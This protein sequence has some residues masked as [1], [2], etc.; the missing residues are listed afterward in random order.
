MKHKYKIH[1]AA[2]YTQMLIGILLPILLTPYMTSHLGHELYGLWVLLSSVMVYFVLSSL[3]FNTTLVREISKTHDTELINQYLSTMLFFLIGMTMIVSIF[4]II[5]Y[6]NFDSLFVIS[7]D[8][9]ETA[10]IAFSM[11]YFSFIVNF[12]SSIF[13]ALLFAKGMLHIQSIIGSVQAIFLAV[14]IALVLYLGYSIIAISL[15]HLFV[16]VCVSIVT[17]YIATKRVDFK[18][19]KQNINFDIL[20]DMAVPSLHY[21]FI[22]LSAIILFYSD[23]IVISSY[24]GISAVAVYALGYKLIDVTQKILFKIVDILIPDIAKLYDAGEYEQVLKLHNKMLI[25]STIF[26]LLGYGILYFW[27]VD[28]LKLWVGVEFTIATDIFRVFVLFGLWHTWVHVSALFIVAMGIHKETSYMGMVDA[29][30]NI[31]LSIILLNHYGLFGV[32]LG[33]LIAHLVTNGWF[34]N[35]WF[36]KNI[37]LKINENKVK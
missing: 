3:G 25:L 5:I 37:R 28:L 1:L 24:L 16:T 30:L 26:G 27:G 15:I 13:N 34:A 20:K 21:F 31:L 22:S 19:S 4:F 10:K 6:L 35:Y 9:V 8:L 23:N 12:L 18:L 29:L 7:K 33:T 14:F 11:V 2:T 17:I 36:Y 32:A